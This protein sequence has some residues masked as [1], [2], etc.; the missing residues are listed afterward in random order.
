M[1]K[2]IVTP[3]R[4]A[5]RGAGGGRVGLERVGRRL[6][7][8][9]P[10]VLRNELRPGEE[11]RLGGRAR[12]EARTRREAHCDRARLQRVDKGVRPGVTRTRTK[13]RPRAALRIREPASCRC[14]GRASAPRSR[15]RRRPHAAKHTD[16]GLRAAIE[17]RA[18][19]PEMAILVLSQYVEERYASDLLAAGGAGIGYLLKEARG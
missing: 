9:D 19:V 6:R 11:L 8:R 1:K 16:E 12:V 13:S 18:R 10:G 5:L 2:L 15:H 14:S 3:V 4:R 17:A 7:Q